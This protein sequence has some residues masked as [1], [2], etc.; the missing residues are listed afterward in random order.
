MVNQDWF[1]LTSIGLREDRLVTT[2]A[3]NHAI[4]ALMPQRTLTNDDLGTAGIFQTQT[5]P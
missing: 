5:E 4:T 3:V 1:A 2:L